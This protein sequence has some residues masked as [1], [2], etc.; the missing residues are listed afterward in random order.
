MKFK[1]PYKGVNPRELVRRCG[2][3][4]VRDPNN[5]ELSF[6]RRLGDN[7]YPRFHV[8]I[9]ETPKYFEI[10]LHLDQ[11]K[12]SYEGQSAH[13]GEYDSPIVIA[14]AKRI[15]AFIKNIYGVE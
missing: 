1:F 10:S 9:N 14:E 7:W 2:Y 11:K 15:T 4:E 6:S 5:P 12:V 13:S 8:Y 3:G